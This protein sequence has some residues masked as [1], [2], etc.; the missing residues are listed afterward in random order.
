M[1][2]RKRETASRT[3]QPASQQGRGVPRREQRLGHRKRQKGPRLEVSV[4][5][6][7]KSWRLT[8]EQAA[9]GPEA[10]VGGGGGER[11]RSRLGHQELGTELWTQK[12]E[13]GAGSVEE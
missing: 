9:P 2:G 10:E 11:D 6:D 7:G 12:T 8:R 5:P 4:Q 13:A 3:S 1:R